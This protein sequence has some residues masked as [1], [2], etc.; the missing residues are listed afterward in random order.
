VDEAR[1]VARHWRVRPKPGFCRG[2]SE[3]GPGLILQFLANGLCKGAIFAIVALGFGLIYTTTR[4]FHIAHAAVC[5]IAGYTLYLSTASWGLPLAIGI[6]LALLVAMAAGMLTD[7]IVYQP[8]ARRSASVAVVLISSL[9]V[10]IIFENV[11]SLAFG[12]QTK[13]LRE[14]IDQT[15]AFGDVVLTH[16]QVAQLLVCV[17]LTT[18]F[19]LFL[20]HTRVGQVCRAVSDDE[21]L[22]AVLGVR[23][24]RVRSLAF[25]LGSFMAGTGGVLI[26]LDVGMDPRIGFPIVL[27]AAVACIIGG[28]GNFL[29][30][31]AGGLLLGMAQDI[32]IWQTSGRWHEAVT[33][34]LLIVF[35]LFRKQGLF[36]V[37]LRAEEAT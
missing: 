35:L 31:V 10:Q 29:A 28:L 1:C 5:V 30:P 25:A 23:V 6:P 17:G 7:L 22:A 32:A 18:G 34:G 9:G 21:D 15:V 4:V 26:A 11:I 24:S 20:K 3:R 19:W 13:I 36:G 33:F 16:V 8:L 37:R 12:S 14:G 27:A 2:N